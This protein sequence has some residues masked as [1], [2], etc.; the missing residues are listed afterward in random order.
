[1]ADQ[2]I[3]GVFAL[4]HT[5]N[6]EPVGQHGRHILHT[7]DR[8]VDVFPQERL[9]DLLHEQPLSADLGE[10]N[11]EDLISRGLDCAER[12]RQL[13][14]DLTESC[15]DPLGLPECQSAPSGPNDD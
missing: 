13:R 7:V 1:M 5:E 8:K 10:R 12:H 3:S 14:G 11:V 4:R 9:L 6:R 2:R 15:L